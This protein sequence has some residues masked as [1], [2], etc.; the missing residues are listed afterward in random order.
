MHRNIVEMERFAEEL[1][2]YVV[3]TRDTCA[4]IAGAIGSANANGCFSD[5]DA[6]EAAYSILKW[7][8]TILDPT[9]EAKVMSKKLT[10]SAETLR[11]AKCL[12]RRIR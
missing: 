9:S 6:T 2:K 1:N 11:D 4:K 12:I 8:E 5:E 3:N 10:T 7:L